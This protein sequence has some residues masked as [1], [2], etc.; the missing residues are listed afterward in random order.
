MPILAAN[1]IAVRFGTVEA[2]KDNNLALSAG[3]FVT[4]H[5]HAFVAAGDNTVQMHQMHQMQLPRLD[6]AER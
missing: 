3:S 4:L 2:L 1:A 5:L 6:R